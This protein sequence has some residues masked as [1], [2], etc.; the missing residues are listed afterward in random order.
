[1]VS[2]ET[3]R[4]N[5]LENPLR[6][7][8]T[9]SALSVYTLLL[10]G[11]VPYISSFG[12][13]YLA[14]IK[15]MVGIQ[16][17]HYKFWV[18]V[19]GFHFF[20]VPLIVGKLVLKMP[21]GKM[22]FRGISVDQMKVLVTLYLLT[23]PFLVWLA[24]R[25]T[26]HSYYEPYIKRDLWEYLIWTNLVMVFEHS[27][28]Q[29]ILISI[30]EPTFFNAPIA[31]LTKTEKA[32]ASISGK[33]GVKQWEKAI[34][35]WLRIDSHYFVIFFLDGILFMLIHVGKPLSEIFLALPA[36]VFLAFLAFKFKSFLPCYLIHTMT[37][38]T[39]IFLI[40]LFH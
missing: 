11:N 40:I 18:L 4:R 34:R 9:F 30:L 16:L 21:F 6:L 39:I 13:V 8:I 35:E 27:S 37:A 2:K 17:P 32:K 7:L 3:Y 31:S 25:E 36:G 26:M 29:G 1:M 5:A 12:Y 15:K 23:I 10:W 22:G 33:T 20:F 38:G 28:L 24:T 19:S 14:F